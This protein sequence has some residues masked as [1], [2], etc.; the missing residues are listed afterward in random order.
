MSKDG[1]LLG[2]LTL[3]LVGALGL[4]AASALQAEHFLHFDLNLPS[5]PQIP[6]AHQR[7]LLS[8]ALDLLLVLPSLG[9]LGVALG[10]LLPEGWEAAL[11]VRLG[12]RRTLAA[13]AG[14]WLVLVVAGLGMGS[15]GKT[16]LSDTEAGFL[17]QAEIFS[18][19]K[20]SLEVPPDPERLV[21]PPMVVDATGKRCFVAVYPGW[22]L[23]LA[24]FAALGLARLAGLL[25]AL[26]LLGGVWL[27][28]RELDPEGSLGPVAMVL[29][30]TSPAL[31]LSGATLSD[32]VFVGAAL[33]LVLT[34]LVRRGDAP[35][36]WPLR[37]LV[38]ALGSLALWTR[39]AS[40]LALFLAASVVLV[41]RRPGRLLGA[42]LV[43]LLAAGILSGYLAHQTG[44]ATTR[45]QVQADPRE[46][47]GFGAVPGR[48]PHDAARV[49]QATV[50]RLLRL[51]GWTLGFPGVLL[52]AVLPFLLGRAGEGDRL[53]GSWVLAHLLLLAPF[54]RAGSAGTG[55]EQCLELLVPLALLATR[56]LQELWRLGPG[57]PARRRIA[58]GLLAAS[59]YAVLFL[60]PDRGVQLVSLAQ[61]ID[62][63]YLPLDQL[64]P[65]PSVVQLE[66]DPRQARGARR[67]LRVRHPEL[68]PAGRPLALAG[69][70][71]PD[72][73]ERWLERR[74]GGAAFLILSAS[75]FDSHGHAKVV[76]HPWQPGAP[77]PPPSLV[78]GAPS[79]P[80]RDGSRRR[81]S[82]GGHHHVA[83][84]GGALHE[85]GAHQAHLEVVLESE[86]GTLAVFI[87]DGSAREGVRIEAPELE[88]L[89]RGD[90][91][92]GEALTLE[93]VANPL[94][95]EVPGDS[96]E[97]RG[98]SPS[99]VGRSRIVAVLAE[100]SVRGEVW[101]NVP[102]D[103]PKGTEG[104]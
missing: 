76:A 40:S 51:E 89:V 7:E 48:P 53:L 63:L 30:A 74:P 27:L 16:L 75:D 61:L 3:A 73:V 37:F 71:S 15:L 26:G 49:A 94:T 103:Y 64:R 78:S 86:T 99:L 70:R 13:L 39:P 72:L 42:A 31:L 23:V 32:G 17:D 56:G 90:Q 62:D 10:R 91:G 101:R 28:G 102:L 98:E 79:K 81:V 97:F 20:L 82:G 21:L 52:L 8:L 67:Q 66:I 92:R 25:A 95:G 47:Y 12:R 33:S 1:S 4:W 84:H 69:P 50:T 5:Y 22:S 35:L 34:S 59:G 36:S 55:P 6:A 46:A 2:T 88:V 38:V 60:L 100:V 41:R 19:G 77:L 104:R 57:G 54:W 68:V 9:L 96:S 65:R 43:G 58:G 83:P 85:L 80:R 14:G 11:R 24:P 45:P 93:A 87:L 29:L 44:S 18:R